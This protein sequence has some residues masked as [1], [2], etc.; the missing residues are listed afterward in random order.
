MNYCH[1]FKKLICFVFVVVICISTIA[2]AFALDS[3]TSALTTGL[4]N[5]SR[6]IKSGILSSIMALGISLHPVGLTID[7]AIENAVDPLNIVSTVVESNIEDY[8]DRSILKIRNGSVIIDGVEYTDVWLSHEAADKFRVNALDFATA[9]DIASE[10]SGIYASGAGHVAGIPMFSE[11]G[12]KGVT[13]WFSIPPGMNTRL[14]YPAGIGS[15]GSSY[16]SQYKY[17]TALYSYNGNSYCIYN[18]SRIYDSPP[19]SVLYRLGFETSDTFPVGYVSI[20]GQE[21][22]GGNG[23]LPF[24]FD[25]FS[26]DYTSSVLNP[27][28]LPEENGIVYRV[29]S[30]VVNNYYN[31]YYGDSESKPDFSPSANFTFDADSPDGI[32]ASAFLADIIAHAIESILSNGDSNVTVTYAPDPS[33]VQPD[34]DPQPGIIATTPYQDL[35]NDINRIIETIQEGRIIQQTYWNEKWENTIAPYFKLHF[36]ELETWW[37]TIMESI[38]PIK[39]NI[40]K[41]KKS[42]DDLPD[43]L[44]RHLIDTLGKGIDALKVVFLSLLGQVKSFLGIWHYVVEWLQSI[45]T[46][47]ALFIG[48]LQN[49]SYT[50][51]LPLYACIAGTIVIAVYKRFGR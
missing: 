37:Q 25:S 24:D 18:S 20:D 40:D 28:P 17:C 50:A 51:I 8:F 32:L 14:F 12:Y 27:D 9:Y 15:I 4:L 6:R 5:T 36:E 7:Q 19:S 46:P 21:F 10:S 49:M 1:K 16:S 2:P 42:L 34:P 45:A 30:S 31:Y 44:E 23:N 33:D 43:N 35:K 13:P 22:R 38:N 48:F 11:S 29:P 39:Q 3:P 26:F 47:F 41:I